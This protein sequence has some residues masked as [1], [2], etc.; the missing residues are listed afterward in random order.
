[1]SKPIKLAL[2]IDDEEIDQ[3]MYQR[4]L[5]NSGLVEEVLAFE[6]ASDALAHLKAS[7]DLEVDVIFLDINMPGMNGFEF[8]EAATQDLGADFAKVVVA[9]LTTSLNAGDERHARSFEVV[10]AFINKPL[11][12]EHV[13]HVATLLPG[14]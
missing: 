5:R 3:R 13:A 11:S 8:L 1:M 6:L 4:V 12:A 9:M 2:L 14:S 7:P 10:R